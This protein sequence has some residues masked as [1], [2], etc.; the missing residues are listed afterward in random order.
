MARVTKYKPLYPW[1]GGLNTSVDPIILDP[2]DLTVADNIVF[3]NSGSRKKRGG[4]A[5][6]N[7]TK[8]GGATAAQTVVYVAD[9]WA[10]VSSAKREYLVAVTT[11]GKV[12][13]SLA[14]S[15]TWAS[16]STLTL[17]VAQGGVTHTVITEDLILGIQ[18]S[19]VPKV[20]NNQSTS[21]NLVAL[22]ASSGSLPFTNAWIVTSFLERLFVA[23]DPANPDKVYASRVGDPTRW[24]ASAAAGTAITLD[25]GVGDGD[26]SG[27]TAIFPGTGADSV[28]YVAKRRHLYRIDCSDPDQTAWTIKLISSQIG[29]LNPNVVATV[30]TTDVFFASDRGIHTLGQVVSQTAVLEG[31][32][33]SLPIQE[34]YRSVISG[35]DRTKISAV[36]MPSLN[37]YLF[38][39]KRV[40]MTTFE[41]IYGFNVEVKKWFRWTS[42]PCNHLMVRFN[43]TSGAE[44]LMAAADSGYVNKLN[45]TALNDFGSAIISRIKSALIAPEDLPFL[46]HQFTGLACIYRSRTTD[47]FRVYYSTDGLSQNSTSFSQRSGGGNVLGTT[48]LGT[49]YLLGQVQAIKPVWSHLK[50]RSGASIQFTFEHDGLDKDFELFGMV[51]EYTIDEEAQNAFTNPIYSN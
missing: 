26:P 28:L 40:G 5:R 49:R 11:S 29:C 13:R 14:D 36:Y 8:I 33:I 37:S 16:F 24:T 25:V 43:K 10:T 15:G 34:D 9:Y 31:E 50:V 22:T 4:Q 42:T 2:Q 12:Y 41:T 27:I 19:G 3:T 32:F 6:Y 48:V 18:G 21:A 1:A 44:E 20:W 30:D 7:S 45:Q 35:A 38:G 23:G 47:S 46:E 51:I 39:C 17:S